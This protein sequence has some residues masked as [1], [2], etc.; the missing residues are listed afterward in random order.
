MIRFEQPVPLADT[1][2]SDLHFDNNEN[3]QGVL[4]WVAANNTEKFKGDLLPL[5][6]FI[7]D[8][9]NSSFPNS[10][11][12]LGYVS[13][14]TEALSATK[15]VTFHVPTLSIDIEGKKK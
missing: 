12:Y 6:T 9:N 10:A 8:M 5:V 13:L 4:T 1:S 11:D 2:L 7:L 15:E 3:D 14:G